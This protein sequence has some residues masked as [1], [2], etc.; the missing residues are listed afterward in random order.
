MSEW[1]GT[2]R[3]CP[4]CGGSG[5]LTWQTM[6][7]SERSY[8]CDECGG[9]GSVDIRPDPYAEPIDRGHPC[10]TCEGSGWHESG[11]FLCPDCNGTGEDPDYD[12]PLIDQ[13]DLDAIDGEPE[14][15]A[16]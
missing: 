16:A 6:H 8:D 11:G 3:P 10:A 13:D 15:E 1:A 12:M 5:A 9:E 2:T 14:R 4:M 7:G